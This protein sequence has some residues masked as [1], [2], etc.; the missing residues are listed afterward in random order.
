MPTVSLESYAHYGK[1]EQDNVQEDSTQAPGHDEDFY[2]SIPSLPRG[3]FTP[4]FVKLLLEQ[5]ESIAHH[6]KVAVITLTES[7][8]EHLLESEILNGVLS[9]LSRLY[10][11]ADLEAE[12]K[13]ASSEETTDNL[14]QSTEDDQQDEEAVIGK[15]A[16]VVLL[17]SLARL[18]G[19]QRCVEIVVPTL[20]KMLSNSPFYVQKEIVGAMGE[21]CRVVSQNHLVSTLLPIYEECALN[22]NWHV[23]KACCN[24]LASFA[25]AMPADLRRLKVEELYDQFSVDVSRSVRTAVTEVLGP[26]IASFDKDNVPDTLLQHFLL[27]GQQPMNDYERASMCAFNF[28]AVVLTAGRSK[29]E[30]MKPVYM[31]LAG[32]YRVPIRRTL[33]CSLHEIARILGP[34]LADRDLVSVFADFIVA[35]DE[36][37]EAALGHVVEFM[38][39]LSPEGRSKSLCRINGAWPDLE[40]SSNWRLRDALAGQLPALCENASATDLLNVLMPLSVKACTD[41]VS[42]IR[43]SGVMS[44]PAL[45]EA[46]HRVGVIEIGEPTSPRST[47]ILNGT[48]AEHNVVVEEDSDEATPMM[49]FDQGDSDD[50][51]SNKQKED[52]LSNIHVYKL[53]SPP[54]TTIRDQVISQTVD[55]TVNGGF[56]SR[57]VAVQI[58]QSL[59]DHGI[60]VTEFEEHFLPLL[61]ERLAVD[62]V[63]NVRIWVARVLS[64]ILESRYYGDEAV[65]PRLQELVSQLQ[66]DSDRD[67]RIY[68]GGPAELPKPKKKKKKSDKEKKKKKKKKAA[69]ASV[70]HQNP[71]AGQVATIQEED[72]EAEVQLIFADGEN[73][74]GGDSNEDSEEG[75][76]DDDDDSDDDSDDSDE[77]S[78]DSTDYL[79]SA[80]AGGISNKPRNRNSFGIGMKVMVGDKL[81]VSGKE[82]R[83]PKTSWDYIQDQVE[84][85]TEERGVEFSNLGEQVKEGQLLNFERDGEDVEE[86]DEQPGAFDMPRGGLSMD[87]FEDEEDEHEGAGFAR[88]IPY[89]THAA[90]GAS[91]LDVEME[92]SAEDESSLDMDTTDSGFEGELSDVN[93]A[94]IKETTTD[95]TTDTNADKD[96]HVDVDVDMD[97]DMDLDN[98]DKHSDSKDEPNTPSTTTS[99]TSAAE[100]AVNGPQQEAKSE[101]EPLLGAELRPVASIDSSNGFPPLSNGNGSTSATTVMPTPGPSPVPTAKSTPLSMPALSYAA[102]VKSN[103]SN[104]YS[105]ED[106]NKGISAHNDNNTTTTTTT[107][108]KSNISSITSFSQANTPEPKS[109]TTTPSAV[110]VLAAAGTGHYTPSASP[111]TSPGPSP[112]TQQSSKPHKERTPEEEV[113]RV[114]NAKLSSGGGK[115]MHSHANNLPAPLSLT[116]LERVKDLGSHHHTGAGPVGL[117]SPG[118]PPISYAS[119]V[120]SGTPSS[121]GSSGA[122]SPRPPMHSAFSPPMSPPKTFSF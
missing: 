98:D 82:I 23:R 71:K 66:Q 72:E 1:Y 76:S 93:I 86:T 107:T 48:L 79:N 5:N 88:V 30:D 37:K 55:F 100:S 43:E 113:L 15:A 35:D 2:S 36:I 27:L 39:C 109:S 13:N 102:L 31:R 120:A 108:T 53:N 59:L 57:V 70:F 77:D 118:V 116:A 6:T 16:V 51:T 4:V 80:K 58:I 115:K 50:N 87:D 9:G 47:T 12:E 41:S 49:S 121:N 92:E 114:L 67:V 90:N 45:W 75:E 105:S 33:A 3:V 40:K 94:D 29:W 21:L 64:W 103:S 34:E 54:K 89:T 18:L 28:P 91:P 99:S 83:K 8:P 60:T 22:E 20:Q 96:M 7:L 46:S 61:A 97:M 25:E 11:I 32:S 42:T 56:R 111:S 81:T 112:S 65:S 69:K 52:S 85:D 26:V 10:T 84:D 122:V 101:R 19:Q 14:H 62:S 78:D 117:L 106:S 74:E 119:V 38:G 73:A 24:V 63:V 110:S 95:T 17:A 68:S 104:G 44:F